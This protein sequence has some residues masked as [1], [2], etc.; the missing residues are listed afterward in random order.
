MV[1]LPKN[2]QISNKKNKTEGWTLWTGI[3]ADQIELRKKR[4]NVQ[5]GPNVGNFKQAAFD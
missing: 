1:N 2:N 5:P 3:Y 4:S